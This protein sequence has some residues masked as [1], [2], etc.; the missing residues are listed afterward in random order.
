LPFA[1]Y[2]P[3]L[4]ADDTCV[5]SLI[6]QAIRL[7]QDIGVKYLEL[8]VGNSSTLAKYPGLVA[9]NL[10]VQWLKP[11]MT[12][13]AALWSSINISVRDKIKKARRLGV[14]TR[15]AQYREEVE[16]YYHLHLVTRSKKHGMP[17]QSRHYFYALWDAFVH[18]GNMQIWLAEYE[19]VVV[20]SAITFTS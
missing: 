7:A 2:C 18:S 15:M 14:Q 8:R 10:Y 13:P 20:A 11:L 17:T 16:H 4:A 3:L 1:D 6:D 12:D 9:G 19:G 5:E